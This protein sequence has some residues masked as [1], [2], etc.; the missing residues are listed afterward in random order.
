MERIIDF[1]EEAAIYV[2]GQLGYAWW[3]CTHQHIPENALD[4]YL[5][6]NIYIMYA[7]TPEE[8]QAYVAR[9]FERRTLTEIQTAK[10]AYPDTLARIRQLQIEG[11]YSGT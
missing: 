3:K 10:R 2:R 1:L 8:C 5:S 6:L 7:V 9:Q 11:R 4:G